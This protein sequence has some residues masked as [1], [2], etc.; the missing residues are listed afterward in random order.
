MTQVDIR[1]RVGLHSG[2]VT[3]AVVGRIFPRCLIFGTDCQVAHL[4]ETSGQVPLS[5][6][7]LSPHS[8]P[9]HPHSMRTR[10]PLRVSGCLIGACVRIWQMMCTR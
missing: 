8:S 3:A 5:S 7:L 2:D 1:V 4:M 10:P 6:A 9:Q